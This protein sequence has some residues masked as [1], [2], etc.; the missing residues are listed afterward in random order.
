MR[1]ETLHYGTAKT[2]DYGTAKISNATRHCNILSTVQSV[3]F[4][5][6]IT[7]ILLVNR[8]SFLSTVQS[9]A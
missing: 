4:T 2:K 1:Q 9:V 3:P 7:I 6:S 8:A 5:S